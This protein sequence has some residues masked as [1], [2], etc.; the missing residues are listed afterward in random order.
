MVWMTEYVGIFRGVNVDQLATE[1]LEHPWQP[2]LE[3][4]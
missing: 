1:L 4:R 3:G 2:G